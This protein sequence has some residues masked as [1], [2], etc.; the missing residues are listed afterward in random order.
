MKEKHGG[1]DLTVTGVVDVPLRE[2]SGA[3]RGRDASGM[4]TLVAVGDA[5]TLVAQASLPADG[6]GELVWE[7]GDL[8][9]VSGT[10]LPRRDGQIEACC[11]DG[12]GRLLLLRE[13]PPRAELID[14]STRTTFATFVLEIP[15]SHELAKAWR[16]A[17]GSGAE[18]AVL[19][20][21]GH[22]LVAKEKDPLALVE[23]GPRGESASG[24]G[25][26]TVLKL[27]TP[28]PVAAGAQAFVPLA[29]W[30]PDER[31]AGACDD[32]SD[33]E[34]GPDDRLYVLSD[35]SAAI[36]RLAE[37]PRGGGAARAEAVWRLARVDG[38]PEGLTFMPDGTAVVTLDT[39]K[40]KRNLITLGPPIAR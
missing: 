20:R 2:V 15:S 29:T 4:L 21:N 36:A 32:F 38:K 12:A 8:A 16:D 14:L 11:V 39:P 22:L 37:L 18:G 40:A 9:D 28:W 35:Q 3:C 24:F 19:L 6:R 34:V 7:T 30:L 26:D 31:L 23:F 10:R 13:A 17:N 1:A 27:G 33:L 25:A 5:S